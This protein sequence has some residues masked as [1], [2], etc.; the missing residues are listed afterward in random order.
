MELSIA[1]YGAPVLSKVATEI[2]SS[3]PNLLSLVED[4]RE[5]MYENNGCGLAAPQVFL[6]IRL[7]WIDS[8]QIYASNRRSAYEFL[9]RKE[10]AP[11]YKKVMI[12]PIIVKTS[13]D[14]IPLDEYC[15]SVPEL[16][17]KIT[18]PETIVV[19]YQD[20]HFQ[21]HTDTFTGLTARII[22]H[23]YDHLQGVLISDYFTPFKKKLVQKKL[24]A[25]LKVSQTIS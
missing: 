9:K 12:N 25:M 16:C 19:T 14:L 2:D 21:K 13:G 20:E 8:M 4:M 17:A 24:D 18:R 10:D 1:L 23:E 7:M 15:I 5:T 3:Y 11:G 22:Q 6:S